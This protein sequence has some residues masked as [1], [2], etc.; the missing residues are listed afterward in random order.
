[1]P[2]R[3]NSVQVPFSH[4]DPTPQRFQPQRTLS[5]PVAD[6]P[7]PQTYKHTYPQPHYITETAQDSPD[8]LHVQD[9]I[10]ATL[11]TLQQ[12]ASATEHIQRAQAQAQR[13]PFLRR[14]TVSA[15]GPTRDVDEWVSAPVPVQMPVYERGSGRAGYG[16][17]LVWT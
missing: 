16:A 14:N 13:R 1:M 6:T 10:K 5:Y 9:V 17:P 4:H 15:R 11:K 12:K 7:P 8:T 2:L 3:R